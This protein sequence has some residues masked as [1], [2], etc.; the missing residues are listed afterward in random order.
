MKPVIFLTGSPA[1]WGLVESVI[2]PLLDEYEVTLV[3]LGSHAQEAEAMEGVNVIRFNTDSE[4]MYE[5]MRETAVHAARLFS[6]KYAPHLPCKELVVLGDRVEVVTFCVAAKTFGC[7]IHHLY[8]GDRSG[9]VDD[10]YRDAIS[11]MSEHLYCISY[12]AAGR[13]DLFQNSAPD[14]IQTVNVCRADMQLDESMLPQEPYAVARFHPVTTTDEPV[15]KWMSGVVARAKAERIKLYWFPPNQDTGWEEID[16]HL[17]M[18]AAPIDNRVCILGNLTRAQYL[19]LLKNAQWIA[20]NSSSFILEAPL[21][22]DKIMIYGHR[23][24]R[25]AGSAPEP[26]RC[27]PTSDVL[28]E[29]LP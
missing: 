25:R 24:Y 26:R 13:C 21:V 22:N 14:R 19:G 12:E 7:T 5:L 4:D 3:V 27:D 20:G 10:Y 18:L 11:S 28:R 1:D 2:T 9:S 6:D 23:Q 17:R 8:A 15:I 16:A 29:R